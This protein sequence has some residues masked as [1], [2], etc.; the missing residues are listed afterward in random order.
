MSSSDELTLSFE[1]D[2]DGPALLA[3][4]HSRRDFL[5]RFGGGIAIF[6]TFGELG[7][8]CRGTGARRSDRFQRVLANRRERPRHVF[9]GKIEMGQ[10]PITSL[11]QML[12]DELDVS[13]EMVDIVMGDTDLCPW[14]RGTWGSLTTRAFGPALRMAAAEAR[15]VLLELAS[16][17]LRV[18]VARLEAKDGVDL[19]PEERTQTHHLRSAREGETHRSTPHGEA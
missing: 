3:Q 9:T 8:A 17:A 2:R 11:P 4:P 12:A 7:R 15:A 13:Y 5:K 18:P 1:D 10:G 19:R 16:E 14:D 6:V